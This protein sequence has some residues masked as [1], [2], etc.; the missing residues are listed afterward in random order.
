MNSKNYK[1]KYYLDEVESKIEQNGTGIWTINAALELG[2]SIPSIYES[3]STRSISNNFTNDNIANKNHLIKKQVI[4]VCELEQ[5]IFFNFACSL[6]QGLNL[7]K[8]SNKWEFFNFKI[9]DV[10]QAWS[11]GCILQ[12]DYL[13]K[14]SKIYKKNRNLNFNF[15]FDIISEKCSGNLLSIRNFNIKSIE[16]AVPCP[17]LSSNIAYYDLIFSKHKIGETIQLQRSFFGLHPLKDKEGREINPYWT[18]L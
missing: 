16:F 11:A 4:S 5:V 12:G 18:K 14:I 13:N 1:N 7:I 3:V 6:Y 8:E 2:V 17:V 15:L 10:F 9:E